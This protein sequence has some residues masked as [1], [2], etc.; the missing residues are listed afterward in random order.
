MKLPSRVYF[1]VDP[2]DTGRDP[3]VL[4]EAMLA[5]GARLVQLRL[6]SVPTGA[7]VE[8]ARR[9]R[10]LTATAGARFIVND[11]IDVALAVGADGVHLGQEDLPVDVARR[12]L[13]PDRWIGFSTHSEAQLAA[14]AGCGAD[15]LSLGPIFVTTSRSPADP[16]IGCD[17]LRTARAHTTEPLVAIGGITAATMRGVLAAGAD[18][19]SVIAAVVRAPDV[20]RAA[21]E[22]LTIAGG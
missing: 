12:L 15:Y 6:K 20:T 10:D 4:A 1:I 14:A 3:V 18:A 21:A 11:R 7:L 17:R 8:I 9:V 16:V 2:L 19:V 5:A 22:L 13:G